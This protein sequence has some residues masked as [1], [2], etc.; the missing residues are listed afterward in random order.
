MKLKLQFTTGNPII[1]NLD[2]VIAIEHCGDSGFK[3]YANNRDY[4]FMY[5]HL[6]NREEV[7]NTIKRW[8]N[9]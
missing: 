1:F 6:E 7:I 2:N 9:E 5:R 3:L 8:E 4:S